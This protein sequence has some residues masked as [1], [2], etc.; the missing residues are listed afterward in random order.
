MRTTFKSL[1]MFLAIL[2]GSMSLTSAPAAAQTVD[3]IVLV[4]DPTAIVRKSFADATDITGAPTSA[5]ISATVTA[6]TLTA[7]TATGA[8][9]IAIPGTSGAAIGTAS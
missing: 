9:M 3:S 4:R 1:M 5:V 8:I 7:T 2:T 6:I